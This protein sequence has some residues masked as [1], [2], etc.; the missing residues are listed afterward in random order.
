M[1]EWLT[2]FSNTVNSSF[3]FVADKL[4]DLQEFFINQAWAIGRVVLLIAVLSAGF[5]YALTGQGLKENVIKIWY[6]FAKYF[7]SAYSRKLTQ[8]INLFIF[9]IR[10]R[11]FRRQRFGDIFT[12]PPALPRRQFLP[13]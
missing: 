3:Y 4:I 11:R 7:L 8:R 10:G 6:K 12:Q 2:N 5:N 1:S 9:I 13:A